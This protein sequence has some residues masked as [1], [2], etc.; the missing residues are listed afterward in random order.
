MILLAGPPGI[1]K[2]T[3]AKV[4]AIHCGYEPLIINA[5]DE[6]TAEKL[7][8]KIFDSTQIHNLSF[9]KK[10]KPKPTCLILDEIDGALDGNEGKSSINSI[11]EFVKTGKIP[12]K[13]K[14]SK[15]TGAKR[16]E[17]A[18]KQDDEFEGDDD[19]ESAEGPNAKSGKYTNRNSIKRPIICICNDLYAK[20]LKPLRKEALVFNFRKGN[21]QKLIS[22]LK[23]ICSF[24]NI[25]I[26]TPT[27]RN[28][29]IKSGSDIRLC[30]NSLQFIS[31]NKKNAYFLN[32]LSKDQLTVLSSKDIGES[33]FDIWNNLFTYTKNYRFRSIQDLYFS[34]GGMDM[35]NEGIY[36]NYLKV[37]GMEDQHNLRADLIDYLSF[38]DNLN[39]RV[40]TLQQF[41]LAPFQ[42]VSKF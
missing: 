33:I 25:V 3:L 9:N 38:E 17:K 1:G 29:S 16:E 7:F 22:R 5:S 12:G 6:R 8:Q 19:D 24:E 28:L 39:K 41:E 35:I 15:G 2:T 36:H 10:E 42:C 30:V 40:I 34:N 14:T 20:V 11:I 27:L 4:L 37:P 32:S 18:E 13:F 21:N 26:D 31:Y 23:D